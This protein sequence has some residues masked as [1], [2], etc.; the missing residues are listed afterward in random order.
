MKYTIP[1]FILTIFLYFIPDFRDIFG[2]FIINFSGFYA[3]KYEVNTKYFFSMNKDKG[4]VEL[5]PVIFQMGILLFTHTYMEAKKNLN[6]NYNL[7]DFSY[8]IIT[9]NLC[10]YAIAGIEAVD[11]IQIYL[12]VF[13]IYFYSLLFHQLL[14]DTNKYIAR[15]VPF[16]ILIFWLIYY[17]LRIITNN[18]GVVPYTFLN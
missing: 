13:N 5:M 7:F 1:F 15:L 12:S 11:R 18:Q 4:L 8:N 17:F 2:K 14:N 6:I 9:I 3:D 10:L 16:I